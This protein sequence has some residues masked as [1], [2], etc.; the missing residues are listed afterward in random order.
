MT[1]TGSWPRTRPGLTGYSPRTMWT[2]VP[3]MVVVVMRISASP[4][5]GRGLGMS[6]IERWSVLWKTTA[7]MVGIGGLRTEKKHEWGRGRTRR[8][9]EHSRR[10]R[11]AAGTNAD[12]PS[13]TRADQ[14][15]SAGSDR[16]RPLHR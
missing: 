12:F 13:G 8:K 15:D 11:T 2:S 7:F 5:P 10:Q 6:S 3:Q 1:P 14:L 9:L 4:A 16:L